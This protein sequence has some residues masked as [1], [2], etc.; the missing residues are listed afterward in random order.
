MSRCRSSW[1]G[2]I[3]VAV[4]A[5]GGCAFDGDGGASKS[6][7]DTDDDGIP[8]VDDPS[9][10]DPMDPGPHCGDPDVDWDGIPD[11]E[12]NCPETFNPDQTDCNGNGVGDACEGDQPP[13]PDDCYNQILQDCLAAGHHPEECH[14]MAEDV[15]FPTEPPQD[16]FTQVFEECLASGD[17]AGE[18]GDPEYCRLL[19]EEVCVPTDPP[20]PMCVDEVLLRECLEQGGDPAECEWAAQLDCDYPPAPTDDCFTLALEE[21]FAAGG[22]PAECVERATLI[23]GQTE[24]PDGGGY[25]P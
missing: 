15:C 16:C 14:Q 25:G 13:P 3:L 19:A 10:D 21:C 7:I 17:A 20:P 1:L 2:M 6:A 5:L 22:D 4:T 18:P 23:C 24:D 11:G 12:D 8:D 9:P